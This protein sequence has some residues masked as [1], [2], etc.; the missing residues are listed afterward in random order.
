[1]TPQ[2]HGVTM[3]GRNRKPDGG[4]RQVMYFLGGCW[5]TPMVPQGVGFGGEEGGVPIGDRLAVFG[6]ISCTL[7]PRTQLS[8]S[9]SLSTPRR[10]EHEHHSNKVGGGTVR[11]IGAWWVGVCVGWWWWCGGVQVLSLSPTPP[12][13]DVETSSSALFVSQTVQFRWR[14]FGRRRR[15]CRFTISVLQSYTAKK[16]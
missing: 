6:N 1:L 10:K 3:H 5:T 4:E 8:R 11:V 12:S 16:K 14:H 7:S 15:H 13:S 9:L 2:H